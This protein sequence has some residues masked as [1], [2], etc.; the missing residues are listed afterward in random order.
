MRSA[1]SAF[2]AVCHGAIAF[3]TGKTCLKPLSKITEN[4][5]DGDIIVRMPKVLNKVDVNEYARQG[6]LILEE[7]RQR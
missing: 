6:D 5:F 2:W 4:L 1:Y 7:A 3:K